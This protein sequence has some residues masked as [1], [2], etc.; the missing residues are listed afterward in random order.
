[1]N[2]RQED[3]LKSFRSSK[4]VFAEPGY[5]SRDELLA[6]VAIERRK[7]A[8]AITSTRKS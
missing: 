3:I 8:P 1:M 2:G 5:G 4:G 6:S 7:F